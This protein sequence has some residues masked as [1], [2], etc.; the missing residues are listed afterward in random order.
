MH[1]ADGSQDEM[2]N[3]VL[4][5]PQI[6][7]EWVGFALVGIGVMILLERILYPL[8]NYEIRRYLQTSIV[9]LIFISIGIYMLIKNK[10]STV[11]YDEEQ[12]ENDDQD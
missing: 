5:F 8:I 10:K 12:E 9:S 11:L 6:K 7:H 1:I 3:Q 4:D 2:K